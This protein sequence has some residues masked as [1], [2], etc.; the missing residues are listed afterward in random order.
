VSVTAT[1]VV[2]LGHH[3]RRR[4]PT[5]LP[6]RPLHLTCKM[7]WASTLLGLAACATPNDHPGLFVGATATTLEISLVRGPDHTFQQ[8]KA[9]VN[10]IDCGGATITPG[11]PAT[12]DMPDQPPQNAVAEFSLDLTQVGADA[13]VKVT[14]GLDHFEAD[15]PT[16]GLP[17]QLDVL[18]SLAAPLHAGDWIELSSGVDS[19]QL[20]G[21]LTISIG[22]QVCAGLGDVRVDAGSIGLQVPTDLAQRWACGAAP[23]SGSQLQAMLALTLW[24]QAPMTCISPKI[25]VCAAGLPTLTS[26]VAVLVQF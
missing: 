9:T 12:I 3:D 20:K 10:G 22:S 13:D 26:T 23:A 2:D 24:P 1:L 6:A 7:R 19:D 15:A 14:D 18:T 11:T 16:V 5:S 21:G 17:R 8:P 25:P 4:S